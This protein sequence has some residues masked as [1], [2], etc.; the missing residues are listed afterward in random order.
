MAKGEYKNLEALIDKL[1]LQLGPLD[2]EDRA[3]LGQIAKETVK[4]IVPDHCPD[5]V[6][7]DNYAIGFHQC[8]SEMEQQAV[9]WLGEWSNG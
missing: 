8:L 1:T 2:D 6:G 7:P 9:E 5:S 3:I 4:A